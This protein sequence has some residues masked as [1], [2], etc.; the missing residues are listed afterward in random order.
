MDQAAEI[1]IRETKPFL[2][3]PG[4]IREVRFVLF[5]EDALETFRTALGS[6][7]A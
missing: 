5:D 2:A 6:H 3:K 7:S 4:S 1:A